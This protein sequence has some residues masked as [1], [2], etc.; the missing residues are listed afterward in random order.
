[1]NNEKTL[2]I[3]IMGKAFNIS[4]PDE[5]RE[6]ILQA[7]EFLNKKIQEVKDDG[8]VVDSDRV[9]I[10]AALGIAHELL[11]LHRSNG[12]DIEDIKRRINTMRERINAVLTNKQNDN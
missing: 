1:M 9:V 3:R 12:F 7:A 11:T 4:C 8:K 10:A 5:E 2:V 6:E